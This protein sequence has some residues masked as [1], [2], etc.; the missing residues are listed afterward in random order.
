MLTRGPARRTFKIA[1]LGILV[2]VAA[3]FILAPGNLS[4][5]EV[6]SIWLPLAG[7]GALVLWGFRT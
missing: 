6:V 3:F 7:L 4:A 1:Y 2:V 5:R